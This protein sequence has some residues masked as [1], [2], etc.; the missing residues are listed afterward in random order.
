MIFLTDRREV[1]EAIATLT[2]AK[3]LWMDTEVADYKTRKPRLS[4][5]QVLAEKEDA[6]PDKVYIFDVLDKPELAQIFIDKIMAN[7]QIEK[8]FHNAKYD[9][10]FLGKNSAENIT[11]TWELAKKFPY[12]ILP[13]ADLKL[14]TLAI[15]LGNFSEIDKEEQGS[16]WGQRPLTEKQLK[17]AEMDPVYVAIV[18]GSLLELK[19]KNNPDPATE[20]IRELARRYQEIFPEWKMLDSEMSTIQERIKKAMQVQKIE[21]TATFKLSNS[22][23]TSKKVAFVELAKLTASLGIDLDFSVT[24]TEKLQKE[25]GDA[26]ARLPIQVETTPSWRLT[27]KTSPDN[28]DKQ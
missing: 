8:V 27:P 20:D 9:L 6:T 3:V 16:D 23:R 19:E 17:Y 1:E 26:I 22:E 4:L 25:L 5:I 13:L 2:A 7:S 12:Y 11:C 28:S 10:K 21:E 15:A 14:K 18:H 24:L